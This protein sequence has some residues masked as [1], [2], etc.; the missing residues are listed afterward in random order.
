MKIGYP[1]INLRI[2]C[3][4]DRTFRLKSWSPERFRETVGN[5]L[6]C[7]KRILEFNASNN[8]LFFRI[9]SDLIPFAS[10]PVCDV[11]WHDE[12]AD[13]FSTIG[14]FIRDHSMRISMHPDQFIVLN[15]PRDDVLERSIRELE[16]HADVLDLLG[17]DATAKIQLHIGGAYGDKESAITCFIERYEALDQRIRRRLVIENDDT[18]YTLEDCLRVH[19][20]TGVPVLFDTLHHSLNP[21]GMTVPD[22]VRLAGETWGRKDGILMVD[23]ST[24]LPGGS[25]R[26][27][28]N[29]IEILHFISFLDETSPYD[30]DIMLEIKD[31]E[32]SAITAIAGAVSDPRFFIP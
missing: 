13:E 19:S 3:R 27:H 2:G 25:R 4:S 10:H 14:M 32:A 11:A 17:M 15:T 26:R 6:W 16:Y 23:Y 28:A 30:F 31:K 22:A 29:T 12:Y 24:H 8:I 18:I 21:S 9:S 20:R 5:N 7:L 1:C